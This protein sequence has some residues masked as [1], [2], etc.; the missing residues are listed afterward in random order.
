MAPTVASVADAP[1]SGASSETTRQSAER[2]VSLDAFRGFTMFWI[3][4]GKPLLLALGALQ[5]GLI[6]GSIRYQLTHS[7]W[8]GLRYYDLIWPSFMLMVGVAIPLS[9]AKRAQTQTRQQIIWSAAKR[10]AVLFLLGSF[11]ASLSENSPTLVE[12]SSALQP[13]ALAYFVASLLA[14]CRVKVQIAVGV[15][16]LVAYGLVLGLVPGSGGP[17]GRYE[18]GA[19]LVAAVDVAIL[20]RTHPEGWGTVLSAIPTIST[21]ILG[22]VIGELLMSGRTPKRKAALIGGI[23]LA[24]ITLG[25]ALSPVVPVIMKLWTASYGLASAGWS[26]LLFLAF[27]L[28]IDVWGKRKWTFPLVVIGANAIAIYLGVSIIPFA[29]IVG[30]FTKP[31]AAGLGVWG[32][33]FM[34]AAMLGAE[35]LVLY[36]MY[37][38][39]IFLKA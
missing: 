38:R 23:G 17:A 37:R 25:F 15:V 6:V 39:K 31:I 19:N 9:F 11:R 16:I 12:L 26:C 28:V 21:T 24:A 14:A 13:I 30:I 4:G 10:A 34:A 35:W 36:W 27:Y 33:L 5:T 29:R 18:I 7:F 20:G 32:E 3:V 22:L 8:E 2:L 1:D